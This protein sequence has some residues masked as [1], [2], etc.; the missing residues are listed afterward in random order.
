MGSYA[1]DSVQDRWAN[2]WEN[3]P[4]GEGVGPTKSTSD[5]PATRASSSADS[6]ARSVSSTARSTMGWLRSDRGRE[7]TLPRGE[8]GGAAGPVVA[9]EG[10]HPQPPEEVEGCLNGLA[11]PRKG[12]VPAEQVDGQPGHPHA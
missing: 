2:W 12:V 11:D 8:Q 10:R 6:S 1:C 3:G 7:L 5:R 9:E 4:P